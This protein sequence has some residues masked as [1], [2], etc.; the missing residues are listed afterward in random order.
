M[1]REKRT[2]GKRWARQPLQPWR[3]RRCA[4][5][6][7][8]NMSSGKGLAQAALT[9]FS[10]SEEAKG[11]SAPPPQ[12]WQAVQP[13]TEWRLHDKLTW[14]EKAVQLLVVEVTDLKRS[15]PTPPQPAA[16]PRRESIGLPKPSRTQLGTGREG[17]QLASG[18]HSRQPRKG[19]RM[20][21][22]TCSRPLTPAAGQG[23]DGRHQSRR[24]EGGWAPLN[25]ALKR[26]RWARK[27]PG[28]R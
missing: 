3:Q 27:G 7:P 21:W 11:P 19:T 22:R 16:T 20:D 4:C 23:S 13:R 12:G 9:F 5:L 17:D 14:L 10:K 6:Q 8:S 18:S 1:L 28:T 26:E 24:A 2:S 25:A 15:I